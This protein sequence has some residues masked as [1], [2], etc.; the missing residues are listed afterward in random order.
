MSKAVTNRR[1]TSS[2][3]MPAGWTRRPSNASERIA[4]EAALLRRL[5][6]ILV[7]LRKINI[8]EYMAGRVRA[9]SGSIAPGSL[10]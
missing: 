1:F 2:R 9:K 10:Q 7:D 5:D 3:F 6:E 8:A 4:E